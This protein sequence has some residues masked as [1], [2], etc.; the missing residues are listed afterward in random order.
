MGELFE[1]VPMLLLA[2]LAAYLIGSLPIAD[3]ISRRN[4]LDIFTAG[5]GLAGASNVK[6]TVGRVPA[7][8]VTLGDFGK[9]AGTVYVSRALGIEGTLVLIPLAGAIVGHWNSVFTG[10]RG[11]DGMATLGGAIMALFPIYGL[12]SVAVALVLSLGF[13]KIPYTSLL[14]IVFAYLTLAMLNIAN[15]GDLAL[16]LGVGGLAAVVLAHAL[17]GHLKRRRGAEWDDV[18]EGDGVTEQSGA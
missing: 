7:A 3:Q 11:G 5:T 9:G 16:T 6:R 15:F 10:F 4:G 13:Q 17:R 1:T 8:V 18:T 2:V 14:N 12:I